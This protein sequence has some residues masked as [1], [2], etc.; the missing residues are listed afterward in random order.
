MLSIL[1]VARPDLDL[2]SQLPFYVIPSDTIKTLFHDPSL[3]KKIFFRPSQR[4]KFLKQLASLNVEEKIKFNELKQQDD[5]KVL[6]GLT[7]LTK[8][9]ILDTMLDYI[10]FT[11]ATEIL[12]EN[13]EKM[14]WKE[15]YLEARAEI[16]EVSEEL[17]IKPLVSEFPHFGHG[18]RR[19]GVS[20]GSNETKI[21]KNKII[22]LEYRFAYH[23]LLDDKNGE[24]KFT[25]LEFG[26]IRGRVNNNR[27]SRLKFTLQEL[28]LVDATFF[29]PFSLMYPQLS[30]SGK[31]KSEKV[32][33]RFCK[34]CFRHLGEVSGGI[35][36]FST[37]TH[38]GENIAEF[39]LVPQLFVNLFEINREYSKKHFGSEVGPKIIFLSE[40]GQDFNLAFEYKLAL[41]LTKQLQD[42]SEFQTTVRYTFV[43]NWALNLNMLFNN[44]FYENSLGFYHYF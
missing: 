27:T 18:S 41:H 1:E 15:K 28:T 12:L 9:K 30:F 16:G 43:K 8:I 31:I 20:L 26:K 44:D 17:K 11:Y 3:V 35:N 7:S 25:Q 6:E 34:N 24:P 40:I 39:S 4:K 10:D 42:L 38:D 36:L 37:V 32:A 13:Q 19:V 22:D 33:N 5:L 2:K 14:A 29:P 21:E 23:D